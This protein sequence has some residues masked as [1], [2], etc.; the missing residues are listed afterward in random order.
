[1]RIDGVR[2]FSAD[3]NRYTK[4]NDKGLLGLT[5]QQSKDKQNSEYVEI[6]RCL[7]FFEFGVAHLKNDFR[8]DIALRPLQEAGLIY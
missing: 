2:R 5:P 1:M 3:L 7:N 6:L 4:N 8:K